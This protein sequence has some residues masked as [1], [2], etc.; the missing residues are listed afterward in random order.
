MSTESPQ[1]DYISTTRSK[2]ANMSRSALSQ[3]KTRIN[4]VL[5]PETQENLKQTLIAFATSHP[6]LATFLLSQIAFS[7]IPLI[8]FIFLIAGIFVFS[9]VATIILGLFGALMVTLFCLGLGSMLLIPTLFVTSFMAGGIWLWAWGIYYIVQWAGSGDTALLT[10][11]SLLMVPR[12][13]SAK[14]DT[15]S[16]THRGQH[17]VAD[18]DNDKINGSAYTRKQEGVHPRKP[19]EN[20]SDMR[21]STEF[22]GHHKKQINGSGVVSDAAS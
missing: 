9:L 13:S 7:G 10:R 6:V 15:E 19:Y 2:L 18:I 8:L 22:N 17:E 11:F 3:I 21:V 20:G 1:N 12:K 14:Q 5:P 4:S 16:D